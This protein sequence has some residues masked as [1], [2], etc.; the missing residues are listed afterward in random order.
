MIPFILFSNFKKIQFFG[1]SLPAW[2]ILFW[3]GRSIKLL[4]LLLE[5]QRLKVSK[6]T[7]LIIFI[8]NFSLAALFSKTLFFLSH[9]YFHKD[10]PEFMSLI[11]N[12]SQL[13]RVYFGS[14]LGTVFSVVLI[15][16]LTKKVKLI[17]KYLDIFFLADLPAIFLY[18]VGNFFYHSHLGKETTS[19][20]GMEYS[21]FGVIRHE[22]SL[23]EALSF[24]VIF[25]IA[26]SI[27]KKISMPGFLSLIIV[28]WI[29]LS[30]VITDFFRAEGSTSYHFEIGL[31]INQ[32]AFTFLFIG[33]ISAIVYIKRKYGSKIFNYRSSQ[34]D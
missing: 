26:W 10:L 5:A 6:K 31:T 29:S 11:G 16:Y 22:P 25:M 1:Y 14:L 34:E 20:L 9:T 32:V 15:S 7:V 30:R 2:N 3:V 24:L 17:P 12:W 8:I 28:S 21:P 23:Y 18:K 19:M 33:C 4:I 27:R 13:G